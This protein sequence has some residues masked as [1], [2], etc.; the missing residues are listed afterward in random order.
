MYERLNSTILRR[1]ARRRSG[2]LGF[3]ILWASTREA[4]TLLLANNKGADQP[5]YVRSLISAFVISYLKSLENRS[6]ICLKTPFFVGFN[7]MKPLATPMIL[8]HCIPIEFS[9]KFDTVKS[10]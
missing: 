6:D 4:S 5:A 9:I 7:M 3:N 1:I 8:N 10:G 2:S